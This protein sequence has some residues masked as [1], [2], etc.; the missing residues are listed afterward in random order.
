M[1]ERCKSAQ[2]VSARGVIAKVQE[3]CGAVLRI[4]EMIAE[5]YKG[6]EADKKASQVSG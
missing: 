1:L 6:E 3:G 2:M 4:K 5:K